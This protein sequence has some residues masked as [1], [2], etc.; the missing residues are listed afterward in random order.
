MLFGLKGP[1]QCTFQRLI[2]ETN[3]LGK[4]V[5]SETWNNHLVHLEQELRDG[6]QLRVPDLHEGSSVCAL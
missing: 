1:Q 4:F 5:Y 2:I 6:Q 3:G